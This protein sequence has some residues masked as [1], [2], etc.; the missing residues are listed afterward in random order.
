LINGAS[1]QQW[2][3][4]FP[5][6]STFDLTI[7]EREADLVIATFGRALW[8]LD[9]IRPLRKLAST[10]GE[11]NKTFASFPAGSTVQAS[12]KNAPGYEWSTWGIWDAAN[13]PA[14]AAVSYYIKSVSD[15]SKKKDS[16]LVKIYNEKNEVIR[17]LKWAADSGFNRR[18]WGMEEK[19]FRMPGAGGRGGR[20]G[21][22]GG[23]S[24]EPVGQQ[25]LPGTYKVVL[26]YK[27]ESDSTMVTLLDDPRL[28]NRNDIKA[29][30][31]ALRNE[32]KKS[33]DQLVEAMDLLTEADDAS[34]K[35]DAYIKEMTGKEIDSLKKTTKKLQEEVKA[36]RESIT[37][38]PQTKQGY[39]QVPTITVMNTYQQASQSISSKPIAPGDQEKAQV[40]K[41]SKL[42]ADAV[43]RVNAFKE[44]SWKQYKEQVAATKLDPFGK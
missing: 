34:K 20:R 12:Y 36:L 41:S 4:G 19:G 17:N 23:S 21:G 25:A 40:E 24:D 43:K 37:G 10:K 13:R 29:A 7:Q 33:G 39:G 32:L 28:G 8:V 1:F 14:G 18:N 15:T 16:V 35:V 2:K 44:G 5:S 42:I 3:N 27:N 31:A 38:K 9:D 11:W 22:G 26:K 6:V 30:Q